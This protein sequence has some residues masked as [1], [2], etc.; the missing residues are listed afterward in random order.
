MTKVLN[1]CACGSSDI[2]IHES[3]GHVL[4]I[5]QRCGR[6]ISVKGE[7]EEAIRRWNKRRIEGNDFYI[8]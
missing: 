7:R 1:D 2:V 5:C 6:Q 8:G 4:V 3:G